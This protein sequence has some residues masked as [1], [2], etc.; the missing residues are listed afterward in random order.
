MPM[1]AIVAL[2]KTAIVL[3]VIIHN[4]NFSCLEMIVHYLVLAFP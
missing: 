2:A 3:M 1:Q 4:K